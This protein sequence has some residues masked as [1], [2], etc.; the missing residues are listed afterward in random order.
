MHCYDHLAGR[1]W[2]ASFIMPIPCRPTSE[3]QSTL[4]RERGYRVGSHCG[5]LY[6]GLGVR[7]LVAFVRKVSG[8][9]LTGKIQWPG[10]L[11]RLRCAV[12]GS[13]LGLPRRAEFKEP[14]SQ[15]VS[16]FET[17]FR[18]RFIAVCFPLPISMVQRSLW[19]CHAKLSFRR[20]SR[21]LFASIPACFRHVYRPC[22]SHQ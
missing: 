21:N 16:Q 2:Q 9:R 19:L 22:S 18:T 8:R 7:W 15:V 17:L 6:E 14:R 1:E 12:L 5:C 20:A 13:R 11:Q 10:N 4:A 3:R